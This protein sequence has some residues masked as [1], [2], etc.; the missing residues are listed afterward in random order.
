[1][2]LN[3]TT[4]EENYP[5]LA[6]QSECLADRFP[7]A[8][9]LPKAFEGSILNFSKILNLEIIFFAE[10]LMGNEEDL[11]QRITEIGPVV[12]VLHATTNFINY[13][14]GVFYEEN[15]PNGYDSFNHAVG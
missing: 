9:Q 1:M 7:S 6:Y 5:Y 2:A 15:C 11:K 4:T 14:S 10:D 13:K 3:G 12:V 8:V